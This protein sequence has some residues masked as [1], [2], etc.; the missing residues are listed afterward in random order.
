[1]KREQLKKLAKKIQLEIKEEEM[2]EFLDNFKKLEASL[3]NFCQ[4]KLGKVKQRERINSTS[5]SLK[6]L[7]KAKNKTIKHPIKKKI[8]THNASIKKGYLIYLAKKNDN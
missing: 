8:L 3:A 5:L 6:D 2:K 1:M 7:E 4:L